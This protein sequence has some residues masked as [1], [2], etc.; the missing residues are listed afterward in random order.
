MIPQPYGFDLYKCY[1]MPKAN[2]RYDLCK[3]YGKRPVQPYPHGYNLCYHSHMAMT[4]LTM[5]RTY[6]RLKATT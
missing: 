5:P 2:V 3:P 6:F 4:Y 1:P